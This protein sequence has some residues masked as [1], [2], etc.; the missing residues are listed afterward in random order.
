MM[1]QARKLRLGMLPRARGVGGMV[2]FQAK[3]EAGLIQRG[4]EVTYDIERDPFD[5]LLVVGGTRHFGLLRSA[6]QSGIPVLQRLDGIN[7]I[8][9]RR[10]TGLRH[11]LRAEAANWILARIR[12]V[13]ASRIVYQSQFVV[14][15]WEETY[16]PTPVPYNVVHNGVDLDLYSPDGPHQ[17]P[18]DSIRILVVE[19]SL[20]GGY[21]LGLDHAIAFS[22]HLAKRIEQ[23]VEL[24]IV[25]RA[26]ETTQHAV[27][28]RTKIPLHWAG[29]VPLEQIP[30]LDRS[31]HLFFAADIHPACPNAV[32]EALA[33][34]LPVV[35]FETGALRELVPSDG[36]AIVAYGSDPWRLE[37]PDFEALAEAAVAVVKD[38]SR[39]RT[40]ARAHAEKYLGL[41]RMI[42]GYLTALGWT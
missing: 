3:L 14:E 5:S 6:S 17:R 34:G 24:M 41:D 25:G 4:I 9:R 13:R 39:Y 32:I 30:E 38:L 35:A 29:L 18:D 2:S 31:A 19:G 22:E 36:G 8:H 12:K 28:Q 1:L 7:W 40:G 21:E 33:C 26:D 42:N 27:S 11:F 37:S 10:K 15:W 23:S 16:G 20:A